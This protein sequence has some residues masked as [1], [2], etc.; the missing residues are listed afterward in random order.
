MIALVRTVLAAS[1]VFAPMVAI[2]GP[3]EDT[4]AV[5]ERWSAAYNSNDPEA[6]AKNNNNDEKACNIPLPS[7]IPLSP[8]NNSD[9][10]LAML[11]SSPREQISST[12]S[13]ELKDSGSVSL[14]SCRH[15][16]W[17]VC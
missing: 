15:R 14:D 12:K 10:S 5:V 9:I 7:S 1:F 6:V 16:Q 4:N 17:Q 11:S 8:P 13:A 2:A 3:A